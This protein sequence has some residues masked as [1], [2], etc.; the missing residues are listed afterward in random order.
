MRTVAEFVAGGAPL[1]AQ[2]TTGQVRTRN[3]SAKTVKNYLSAVV[4]FLKYLV[5]M[6][7]TGTEPTMTAAVS[8][9]RGIRHQVKAQEAKTAQSNAGTLYSYQYNTMP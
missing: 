8:A 3:L 1:I 6:G 4:G 7:T 5:V 2:W 9:R